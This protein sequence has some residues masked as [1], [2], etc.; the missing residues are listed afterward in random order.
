MG[1]NKSGS[2]KDIYSSKIL[3]QER[4]KSSNKHPKITPNTTREE[5]PNT[6]QINRRTKS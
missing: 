5:R 1:H 6:A 2:E 4:R 3:T